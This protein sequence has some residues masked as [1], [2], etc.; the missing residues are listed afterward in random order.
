MPLDP[1]MFLLCFLLFSL[2]LKVVSP[3]CSFFHELGHALP[4]I[5]FINGETRIKLVQGGGKEVRIG[6]LVIVYGWKGIQHGSCEFP[7]EGVTTLKIAMVV[8]GGPIIS[9]LLAV[10][11]L[12]GLLNPIWP[13]LPRLML[14]VIFYA[15]LRIF[16]TSVI[17]T[18]HKFPGI[19]GGVP[20]DG[21]RFLECLA[22]QGK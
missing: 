11:S 4:A 16:L 3:V 7:I 10:F 21:K 22:G 9:G 12:L 6:K 13:P 19:D 15:N 14:T 18:V 2:A 1:V 17:P 8:I 20:S 5:L